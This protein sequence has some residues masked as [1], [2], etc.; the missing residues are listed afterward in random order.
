MVKSLFWMVKNHHE[1]TI[2]LQFL[3]VKSLFVLFVYP[4]VM[5]SA[6]L[7][8]HAFGSKSSSLEVAAWRCGAMINI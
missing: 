8:R 6:I 2:K 1:T 3:V 4:G 5:L 7:R